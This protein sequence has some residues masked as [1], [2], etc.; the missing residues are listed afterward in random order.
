MFGTLELYLDQSADGRPRFGEARRL[1]QDG[2]DLYVG[3]YPTGFFYDLDEDG[4]GDL[5]LANAVGEIYL[6]RGAEASASDAVP[7]VSGRGAE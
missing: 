1:R 2:A 4:Y 3:T 5:V 6:A 7:V